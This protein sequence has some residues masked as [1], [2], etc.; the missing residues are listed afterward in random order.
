MSV[1]DK[2]VEVP[3][4]TM[5]LFFLIDTSKS[6][7]GSSIAQVNDAMREILPDLKDISKDNADAKIKI[8]VLSFSSGCEWI[9]VSPEELDSFKWS[10]LNAEGITDLGAACEEL[11]SKL[12]KSAFLN[13]TVG[14][15]APV[16]IL[17]TDGLPTDDYMSGIETLRKNKWF[18]H[19]I[20]IALG[21][22]DANMKVLEEFT[23]NVETAIYLSDKSQL[24]KLIK[25]ISIRSSQVGSTKDGSTP[26]S[27]KDRQDEVAR[28]IKEF[29][30][31]LDEDDS[32][33]EGW[34]D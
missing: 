11:N 25:F 21:V 15:Y 32:V 2:A 31:E 8:A 4:K 24:K 3:R 20:K 5:V 9:T 34:G 12:D 1:L 7:T 19:A 26:E 16:I 10:N 29:M 13:D 33:D 23:G 30:E 27:A 14:N 17:I 22:E 28:D 6:M 18:K